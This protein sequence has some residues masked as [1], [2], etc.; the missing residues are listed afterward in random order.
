[1]AGRMEGKVAV[2]T[3]AGSGIGRGTAEVLSAEDAAIAVLDRDGDAA[4]ETADTIVA[5]G[6]NARPYTAD[7][8]DESSITTVRAAIL[9]DFGKV[10][11]LV[12]VAGVFD[13]NATLEQTDPTLFDRIMNI[14]VRGTYLMCR[15]FLPDLKEQENA[16]IINTASIAGIVAHAGGFAYTASKHAVIGMTKSIASD[17][18]PKL[19]CNAVLPGLVRTPLTEYIWEDGQGAEQMDAMF[20]GTP[21]GRYATPEELGRAVLFLASDDSSYIYGQSLIVDGGWT[22]S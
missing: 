1:M 12:N 9:E 10:T 19:R 4:Q 22:L 18:G 16:T 7:V 8:A 6:G 17:Y 14:N 21:S 11:T 15:A 2:V 13:V 20:K 3:G 5:A